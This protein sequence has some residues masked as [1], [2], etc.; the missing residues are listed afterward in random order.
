M[1]D[2]KQFKIINIVGARPNFM[3]IAPIHR[4]MEASKKFEPILLHTGQH[5]DRKMSKIFF[6]DLGL[7]KPQ[8]YLGVGSG[9]HAEQ[10][11]HIMVGIEKIILK[12]KPDLVL[13]VGDVNSTLAASLV[14]AKLHIPIAH[15][16]AGLRSFDR[17]MPEEINRIVTDSLAQFL[18]VT[19][20][21]GR[22]N[23][24]AEG[25]PIEKIHLVG[26]VMIDS[27]RQHQKR[28]K[29]SDILTKLKLDHQPYSL[30]T[31]H[32]PSNVDN[33]ENFIRLLNAFE[34]I[35][36]RIPIIF[37]IHPRTKKMIDQFRLTGKVRA[38]KN[39]KLIDPL[40]YL[41]FLHLMENATFLLTDSGGIQEE[42][43]VLGIP[44]LTLRKNTERPVTINM[45]TN[46]LVGMDTDKIV[47]ESYQILSGKFKQGKTPPLWDG[48]ASER[49]IKILEEN[50]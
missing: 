20:E 26:N 44:C 45:G 41:D 50:L 34:K 25:I 4:A 11:A 3:K 39:F 13:V 18:F 42:T 9:S 40:G 19:E 27:L 12:L 23:L 29:Q 36:K 15:V 31:L 43:T 8:I 30:L 14:A 21:S 35:E 38:M 47:R 28:S 2:R 16:E 37:P 32:R 22:K 48:K 7:P 10:T 5:Y 24:I 6:N 1:P 17:A 46:A 49:I 33:P